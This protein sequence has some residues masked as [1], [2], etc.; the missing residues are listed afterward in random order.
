MEI[1]EMLPDR[2]VASTLKGLWIPGEI[3]RHPELTEKEKILASLIWNMDQKPHH[4]Y[5]SNRWFGLQMGSSEKHIKNLMSS[6]RKKGIIKQLF[7]NVKVRVVT[8][9][10]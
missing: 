4:C 7:W 9:T 5:A 3:L 2:P 10:I 1:P 8:I 6:L